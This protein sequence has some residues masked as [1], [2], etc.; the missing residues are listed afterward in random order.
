MSYKV[1]TT[2]ATLAFI[3]DSLGKKHTQI[4]SSKKPNTYKEMW[5]CYFSYQVHEKWASFNKSSIYH[6]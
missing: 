5:N 3:S 4:L 6:V 1:D 2:L